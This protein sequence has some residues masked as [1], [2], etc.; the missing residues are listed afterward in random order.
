MV[1]LKEKFLTAA[2]LLLSFI[3]VSPNFFVMSQTSN[4]PTLLK[5]KEQ[6]SVEWVSPNIGVCREP[7]MV[8]K[9]VRTEEWTNGTKMCYAS[10]IYLYDPECRDMW[11]NFTSWTPQN[12]TTQQTSRFSS[13]SS[14]ILSEGNLQKYKKDNIWFI[15]GGNDSV[16]TTYEHDDNYESYYPLQ[17]NYPFALNGTTK[18][19]THI[20]VGILNGWIIGN[21]SDLVFVTVC[22]FANQLLNLLT[23]DLIDMM[24][25]GGEAI[26]DKIVTECAD[27]IVATYAAPFISIIWGISLFAKDLWDWLYL[28]YGDLARMKWVNGVV[29]ETY[30]PAQDGWSWGYD[31]ENFPFYTVT[32][33]SRYYCSGWPAWEYWINPR[34]RLD[35]Y[36]ATTFKASFGREGIFS[37]NPQECVI[38]W[39]TKTEYKATY[40]IAR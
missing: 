9:Y 30:G 33:C 11:V 26:K 13:M 25:N 35:Y 15:S 10:H 12:A 1:R 34:V 6:K 5:V 7:K 16:W 14:Q 18:T 19:H 23:D 4:V 38:A 24:L 20:P 2:C 28:V 37:T 3:V 39:C 21:Y 36:E 27:A 31:Y 8:E 29:R 17:W 40:A 22:F 32:D